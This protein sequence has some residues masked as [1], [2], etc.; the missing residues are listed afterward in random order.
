MPC[1]MCGDR[2]LKFL[3]DFASWLDFLRSC[4]ELLSSLRCSIEFCHSRKGIDLLNKG[5]KRICLHVI[6]IQMYI[7]FCNKV[8]F[9]LYVRQWF[10][11]EYVYDS[12]NNSDGFNIYV[13]VW[14]WRSLVYLCWRSLVYLWSW[15]SMASGSTVSASLL[16]N[17]SRT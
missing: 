8:Y 11:I 9:K 13:Q 14:A 3:A 6:M 16:I 17:N 15:P 1:D 2:K 5:K 7:W 4:L 10:Y 12:I